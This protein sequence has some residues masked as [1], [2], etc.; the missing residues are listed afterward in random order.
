MKCKKQLYVMAISVALMMSACGGGK[1][2]SSEKAQTETMSEKVEETVANESESVT[3][4]SESS[5]E[6]VN[7]E[8]IKTELEETDAI[9]EENGT[10]S[11]EELISA[12]TEATEDQVGVDESITDITFDG[13][14]LKIVVD[15]SGAETNIPMDLLAISRI[16]SITDA[17]LELDNQYYNTWETVTVDFGELGQATLDKTMVK[18]EGFGKFFDFE[19]SILQ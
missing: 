2:A 14:D 19:D 16:S 10:V 5:E 13:S 4:N 7:T 12:V 6:Q 8:E 15:L 11:T 17:I 3:E 9:G 1:T 18:D